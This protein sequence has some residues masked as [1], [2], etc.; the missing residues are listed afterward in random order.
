MDWKQDNEVT[1]MDHEDEKLADYRPKNKNT[2]F[3]E[4]FNRSEYRSILH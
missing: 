1:F 3:S 4:M 2:F